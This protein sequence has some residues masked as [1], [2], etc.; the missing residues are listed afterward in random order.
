MK[1]C[2]EFLN[3][4]IVPDV[5]SVLFCISILL[6]GFLLCS[7]FFSKFTRHYSWKC[8]SFKI[9]NLVLKKLFLIYFFNFH[10]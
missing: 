3:F 4:L 5:I 1:W 2:F 6:Y 10:F 9:K 8:S 7:F